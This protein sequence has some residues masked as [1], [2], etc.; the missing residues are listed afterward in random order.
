MILSELKTYLSA[1][2]RVPIGDLVNRFD[3]SPDA[4]RGMLDVFIRK[5]R[6]RRV[7]T[8]GGDCSGCT[9]CAAFTLEIYEW[10][11]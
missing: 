9:K 3:T 6:L 2:R 8:G 11:G 1:N 7:P 4:I 5:G 10:M